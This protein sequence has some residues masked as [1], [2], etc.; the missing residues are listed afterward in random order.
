MK[1]VDG[2][3]YQEVVDDAVKGVLDKLAAYAPVG[4]HTSDDDLGAALLL[5]KPAGASQII[6]QA[7]DQNIRFTLDGSDPTATHG[8]QLAAGSAPVVI[9]VPGAGI[10]VI[11][12]AAGA[13]LQRQWVS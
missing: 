1:E 5:E 11:Q 6:L 9:A 10:K 13:K 4:D 12:E 8:F 2:V 3:Y 7:L